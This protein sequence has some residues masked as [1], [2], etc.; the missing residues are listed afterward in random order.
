MSEPQNVA[1]DDTSQRGDGNLRSENRVEFGSLIPFIVLSAL[2]LVAL[3]VMHETSVQ[4]GRAQQAVE[5][6]RHDYALLEKH[7]DD[8]EN[9]VQQWNDYAYTNLK[10]MRAIMAANKIKLIS[11]DPG[12]PPS[13]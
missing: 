5:D 8:S 7:V 4:A 2:F 13:K 9:R 6:A 11:K 3:M 12:I 1:T 10:E